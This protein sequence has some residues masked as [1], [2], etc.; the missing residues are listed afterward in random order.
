RSPRSGSQSRNPYGF[1]FELPQAFDLGEQS[2]QMIFDC[3]PDQ[4]VIDCIVAVNNP[5]TLGDDTLNVGDLRSCGRIHVSQSCQ[6][7]ANDKQL[8]FNEPAQHLISQI[9][10]PCLSAAMPLDGAPGI[11]DI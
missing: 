3:V 11:Q 9:I 8:A 5:V 7:S 10:I 4:Q 2:R 6:C 1:K